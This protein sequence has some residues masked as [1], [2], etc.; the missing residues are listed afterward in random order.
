MRKRLL[1]GTAA[2]VAVVTYLVVVDFGVFAGRIHPGVTVNGHDIGGMTIEEAER[3]LV[4][5]GK[6][7]R[8][9]PIAFTAEGF[10]CRFRPA[11]LGW[12][13][14]PEATAEQAMNVGRAG[15]VRALYERIRAWVVGIDVGWAGSSNTRKMGRFLN[16]C[17]KRGASVGATVDEPQLRYRVRQA[18]VTDAQQIFEIPLTQS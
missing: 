13:P 4:E 11:M 17:S 9:R 6:A 5:K 18:I 10:D 15:G 3:A 1:L 2:F 12:R 7:L 8:E 14:Q 16:D